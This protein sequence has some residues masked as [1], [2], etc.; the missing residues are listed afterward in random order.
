MPTSPTGPW[1]SPRPG[2]GGATAPRPHPAGFTLLE[3]LVVLVIVGVLAGLVVPGLGLPGGAVDARAEA[4]RFAALLE[5][6]R[7]EA[8]VGLAPLAVR[9]G[10]EGYRFERFGENGWEAIGGDRL[11][12]PRAWPEGL[13]VALSVEGGGSGEAQARIEL[14]GSGEQ[15][16]FSLRL[17]TS[18]GGWRVS[19]D[20]L[21]R[22]SLAAEDTGA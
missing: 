20:A 9:V 4:E 13:A 22:V 7:Q 18:A 2:R 11:L 17:D 14:Y 15:I 10:R 3:L 8:V 12:R 19:G 16:P 6:A 21:G 1:S 5:L